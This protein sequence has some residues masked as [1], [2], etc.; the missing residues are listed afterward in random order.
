M[1]ERLLQPLEWNSLLRAIGKWEVVTWCKM[2]FLFGANVC[3]FPCP[4][5]GFIIGSILSG[6]PH[7]SNIIVLPFCGELA[8]KCP[9]YRTHV[10]LSSWLVA[11]THWRHESSIFCDPRIPSQ[12]HTLCGGVAWKMQ[13]QRGAGAGEDDLEEV[14]AQSIQNIA[15]MCSSK[16]GSLSCQ[17]QKPLV[18]KGIP[19]WARYC[20]P[21][22]ISGFQWLQ[23]Q[24]KWSNCSVLF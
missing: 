6:I 12:P 14:Y 17:Q 7:G 18:Q 15:S 8:R 2:S 22:E 11:G 3:V 21:A 20:L 24:T 1:G 4:Q 19:E 9:A 23:T 5:S 13:L 16:D 10:L